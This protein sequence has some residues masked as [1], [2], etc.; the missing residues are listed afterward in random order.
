MARPP[1]PPS[2]PPG[3]WH[4]PE[5][6][7]E[8]F[9][10]GKPLGAQAERVHSH[11]LACDECCLRLVREAEFIEALRAGLPRFGKGKPGG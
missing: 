5:D 2:Q 7:L 9:A 8:M 10:M 1:K 4:V 3:E 6:L 11:L